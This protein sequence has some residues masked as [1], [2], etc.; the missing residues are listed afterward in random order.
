MAKP[1]V[2]NK[3]KIKALDSEIRLVSSAV[4]IL[5]V[6]AILAYT[7][8]NEELSLD[9]IDVTE[10]DFEDVEDIT[11]GSECNSAL[12]CPQPRCPGVRALCNN[13][14]CIIE[15]S[16]SRCID[17]KMPV[18]GNGICEDG[19]QCPQDCKKK[20]VLTKETCTMA[21]GSWNECGSACR[22]MSSG[23]CIAMCVQQC[24]CGGSAGYKC[25]QGYTCKPDSK[26]A[27]SKGICI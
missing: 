26:V 20:I 5:I 21:G 19:E 18:C 9:E 22:G 8:Q 12:D 23:V 16:A 3:K 25:P 10:P 7:M 2:K 11:L 17:L 13:G 14:F 27:G 6:A 24:E 1:A 4:L 15:G